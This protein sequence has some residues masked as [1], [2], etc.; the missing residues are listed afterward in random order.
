MASVT[1]DGRIVLYYQ[2]GQP[3]YADSND[4]KKDNLD[5]VS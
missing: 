3:V 1:R 2:G 5:I 4:S